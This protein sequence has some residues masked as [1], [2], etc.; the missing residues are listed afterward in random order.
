MSLAENLFV[1]R[2]P[3]KAGVLNY[4][5]MEAQAAE[6]MARLSLDLRSAADHRNGGRR[7]AHPDGKRQ[8]GWRRL[9]AERIEEAGACRC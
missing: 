5:G 9:S 3:G 1:G 2:W 8:G 6:V 7:D 4:A